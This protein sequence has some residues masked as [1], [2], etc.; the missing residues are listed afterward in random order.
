MSRCIITS[1]SL[2]NYN[3]NPPKLRPA[4]LATEVTDVLFALAKAT[5]APIYCSNSK[6]KDTNYS[7]WNSLWSGQKLNLVV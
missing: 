5:K 1:S 4:P 3:V 2:S 6:T 7:S